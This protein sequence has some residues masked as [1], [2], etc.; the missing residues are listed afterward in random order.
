[1]VTA[2][3]VTSGITHVIVVTTL[4]RT[5]LDQERQADDNQHNDDC[6]ENFHNRY[7]A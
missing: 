1:M 2:L 5:R 7:L 4:T 3:T 6:D